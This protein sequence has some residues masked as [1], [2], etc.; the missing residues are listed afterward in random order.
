MP[1]EYTG[2]NI[3]STDPTCTYL[4]PDEGSTPNHV[5]HKHLSN[6]ALRVYLIV[7]HFH[8]GHIELK[9]SVKVSEVEVLSLGDTVPFCISY[10]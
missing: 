4:I 10:H 2:R 9:S 8:T 6:S 3:F 5:D 7:L 1:T